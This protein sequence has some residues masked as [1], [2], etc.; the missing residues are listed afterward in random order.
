MKR[1]EQLSLPFKQTYQT[2]YLGL[3]D[4]HR[5]DIADVFEA[6]NDWTIAQWIPIDHARFDV[7]GMYDQASQRDTAI[8]READRHDFNMRLRQQQRAR[9]L[10]ES[11]REFRRRIVGNP[12]PPR[13]SSIRINDDWMRLA[14]GDDDVE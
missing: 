5:P 10:G 4:I 3:D 6:F 1:P 2:Q 9:Q 11:D 12:E 14:A 7:I 8:Y 13:L